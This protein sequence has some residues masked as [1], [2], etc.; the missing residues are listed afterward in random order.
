MFT[1]DFAILVST[2]MSIKRAMVL[3]FV[4]S[5][6]AFAGLYLG[7][8]LGEQVEASQWIFAVGAGMF[9]YVALTD[10]VKFYNDF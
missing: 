10:L 5:L 1:G 8:S 6:T 2:G 7:L 4:S 9:L 3:N